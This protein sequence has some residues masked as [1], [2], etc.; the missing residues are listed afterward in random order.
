MGL[1]ISGIDQD[2]PIGLQPIAQGERGMVQVVRGDTDV[3][4]GERALDELVVA[5]RGPE[6]P[7]GERK[8]GVL[9]LPGEGILQPSA[10]PTRAIDIPDLARHEQRGK[11]G[12][13]LDVV[14]VRMRQQQ[15]PMARA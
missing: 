6:L 11:E 9:H 15:V 4:Q 2:H 13:A 3:L 8:I 12:E 1:V 5:D 14:P 10:R 7:Q